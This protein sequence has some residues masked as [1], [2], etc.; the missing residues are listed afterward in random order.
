VPEEVLNGVAIAL[1]LAV[2]ACPVIDARGVRV[3]Q[4]A[5]LLGGHHAHGRIVPNVT[6]DEAR[7]AE[8]RRRLRAALADAELL[9]E[10]TRDDRALREQ[11][12]AE[13]SDAD[14]DAEFVRNKPPHHG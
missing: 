13:R 7:K 10:E 4:G 2:A 14:R 1:S 8:A 12:Q 6:E 11:A 5:P 3:C 9:P